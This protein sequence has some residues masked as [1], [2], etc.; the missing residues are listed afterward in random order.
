MLTIELDLWTR[1][2]CPSYS[3][4]LVVETIPE[5]PYVSEVEPLDSG[6]DPPVAARAS[7]GTTRSAVLLFL[8]LISQSPTFILTSKLTGAI[9]G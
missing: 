1:A 9:S 5:K 4:Q 7:K 8:P 3:C 6:I 2:S